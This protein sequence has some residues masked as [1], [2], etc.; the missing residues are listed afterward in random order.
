MTI[1]LTEYPLLANID[2]P[3]DLRKSRTQPT[4]AS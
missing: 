3:D 1:N 4:H 2:T